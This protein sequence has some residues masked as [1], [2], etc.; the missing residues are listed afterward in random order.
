MAFQFGPTQSGSSASSILD[1]TQDQ[2]RS[3]RTGQ[4]PTA[5]LDNN[6]GGS[7]PGIINIFPTLLLML[8]QSN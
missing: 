5:P 8:H 3:E 6:P 1:Y 7:L 4:D 2:S